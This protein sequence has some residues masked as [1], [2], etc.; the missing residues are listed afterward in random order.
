M[1]TLV[2]NPTRP[3]FA[4]RTVFSLIAV[5]LPASGS[6]FTLGG[7]GNSNLRGWPGDELVFR[8]NADEC[9]ISPSAMEEAVR[10]ALDLWS[11]VPDSR[12][13]LKYGGSSSTTAA[14]ANSGSAS[15]APVIVCDGNFNAT[16][17]A[18]GDDGVIG[19]GGFSA[20]NDVIHYGSLLLNADLTSSPTRNITTLSTTALSI[21]I[22][23]EIGH[24]LGFGH[25]QYPAALMHYSIGLKSNLVLAQDDMDAMAYLYP[26]SE[27][28]DGLLGCG[29]LTTDSA[30]P[31]SGAALFLFWY[32]LLPA[33]TIRLTK[34]FASLPVR[35]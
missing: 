30:A 32:V 3:T 26:R 34:G 22:A 9:G 35:S 21:T 12:L 33:L 5:L 4:F 27:P 18:T 28:S 29:N 23:H 8:L 31:G 17:G 7:S 15:D 24:V 25:S 16:T 14:Q 1:E 6:A 19:I 11:R 2:K 10:D 13:K 20:T